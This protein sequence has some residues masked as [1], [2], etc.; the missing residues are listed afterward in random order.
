MTRAISCLAIVMHWTA[1]C[2]KQCTN[3][4]ILSSRCFS[5]KVSLCFRKSSL[6]LVFVQLHIFYYWEIVG[7]PRRSSRRRPATAATQFKI[8]LGALLNNLGAKMPHYVR[9]LRP[10]DSKQS[11][12]F[13]AALV[14]HQLTYQG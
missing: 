14:E 11:K 10:N 9:C 6:F 12:V 13:E 2:R 5:P 4:I 3:V 7:N 1:S 8:S